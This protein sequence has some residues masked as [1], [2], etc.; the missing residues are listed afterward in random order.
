LPQRLFRAQNGGLWGLNDCHDA[1][2][3]RSLDGFP[4]GLGRRRQEL[5]TNGN[6]CTPAALL[7]DQF[8]FLSAYQGIEHE[9]CPKLEPADS[10]S[11]E[12]SSAAKRNK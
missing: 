2:R 11:F 7:N 8:P 9:A 4:I 12:Q 10:R 3:Q 5:P 1:S 6:P